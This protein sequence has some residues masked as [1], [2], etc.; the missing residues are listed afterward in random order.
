MI[1]YPDRLLNK[2][3]RSPELV[4]GSLSKTQYGQEEVRRQAHHKR[5]VLKL[6]NLSVLIHYVTALTR[7]IYAISEFFA[8][9]EMRDIFFR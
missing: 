6:K 4:E 7:S 2:Q 9:F 8:R 5:L 3:L 1:R